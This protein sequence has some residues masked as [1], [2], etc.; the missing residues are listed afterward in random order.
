MSSDLL[1]ARGLPRVVVTGMGVISC[2]GNGQTAFLDSLRNDRS[3]LQAMDN[4]ARRGLNTRVG[5][6]VDVSALP[7]PPR[8]LRRFLA[9]PSLYAWHAMREAI[10]QA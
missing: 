4:F 7:E 2:L 5:G 9:Q 8:K 10:E 1:N 3:G 6:P